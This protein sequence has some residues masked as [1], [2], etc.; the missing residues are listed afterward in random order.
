TIVARV[1]LFGIG[2]PAFVG[3]IAGLS[4][5][6]DWETV[7]L[8]LHGGEFGKK[9]P[10]FGHDIGFY[11]FDLPFYNWAI[12]WVFVALVVAFVG[13][14]VVQYLFG[15]IRLR[16]EERTSELHSRE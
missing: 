11:V 5:Q 2:I 13:A 12:T 9:D 7:Q 10:E 1:R 16:S 14:V 8:F 6:S 15:G 4:A 3:V